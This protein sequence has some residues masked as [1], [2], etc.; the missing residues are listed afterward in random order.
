MTLE[1]HINDIRERLRNGEYPNEAAVSSG[2]VRKLLDALGW[3]VYSTQVVFPEYSV[4]SRRVDFALCHPPSKPIV[5]IE[6][7]QHG[8]I[9]GAE[10]QLFEYAFHEGVPIAVLTDGQEWRFF[11]PSGR[12]DYRE[13]RVYKLDLLNNNPENSAGRLNRYLNYRAVQSGEAEQALT[14]DYRNVLRQRKIDSHLPQAWDAVTGGPNGWFNEVAEKTEKLCGH[15]PTHEEVLA[16]VKNL[17]GQGGYRDGNT[18]MPPETTVPPLQQ[19]PPA[20]GKTRRSPSPPTTIVVTMPNG[21]KINEK[22]GAATD[23]FVETIE[24]LGIEEVVN[25]GMRARKLPLVSTSKPPDNVDHHQSGQ[26]YI[27]TGNSTER[28]QQLLERMAKALGEN[29]EVKIEPRA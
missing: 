24:K 9:D 1:E 25:L 5:F 23:A 10:R 14:E 8:K 18:E 4:E 27:I 7:K 20:A 12:G 29:I 3:P 21:D 22:R 15:K 19:K 26:Y 16:F 6:V 13:R 28:K 2:I 11:L 17:G